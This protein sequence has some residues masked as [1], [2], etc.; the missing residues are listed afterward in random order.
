MPINSTDI[1]EQPRRQHHKGEFKLRKK[2]KEKQSQVLRFW[3]AVDD[4]EVL[5][6]FWRCFGCLGAHSQPSGRLGQSHRHL[7]F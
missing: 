6:V 2:K 7:Y 3:P 4:W 1:L 5:E